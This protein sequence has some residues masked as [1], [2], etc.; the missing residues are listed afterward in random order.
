MHDLNDKAQARL[1]QQRIEALRAEADTR[2]LLKQLQQGPRPSLLARLL[3]KRKP[4]TEP[5]RA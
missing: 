1:N 3:G 5:A 4:A 2:R